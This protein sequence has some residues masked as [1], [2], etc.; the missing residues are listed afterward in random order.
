AGPR[1]SV[2]ALARDL[3][4]VVDELHIIGDAVVP[5]SLSNAI[6]EGFRVGN[7]I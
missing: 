3:E 1:R 5:R 6:H 4:L 2:D 7:R